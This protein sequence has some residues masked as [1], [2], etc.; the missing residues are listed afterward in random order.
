M[1]DPSPLPPRPHALQRIFGR[2]RV[3]IGM[4]HLRPLP[5]SPRFA[6][7]PV[8]EVV[9]HAVE[10]ALVYRDAG[11]DGLIVE[12]A[13]DVPFPKPGDH[14]PETAAAMAVVASAVRQHT[15]LPVGI[16]VLANGVIPSLAVA[17]AAGAGFVRANQWV[18]AY[19]ANEGIV[20]GP[21]PAATR[22]R[23]G[24]G[25]NE[26]AVFADVRVKHG[27]HAIVADRSLAE[28]ARDVQFFDADV[29]IATGQRTGDPTPAAEVEVLREATGQPV[30]IG[31]GMAADQADT[32][33]VADG[34]IVGSSLKEGGAWWQPLD[35]GRVEKM[36]AVAAEV[37]T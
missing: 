11:F 13:W 35:P 4:L 12:N 20:E 29:L 14:G 17:K 23:A 28:Q 15:A 22:Y 31:S 2:R 32:L 24:I 25:A 33:A 30:L 7:G 37:W 8:D 10:E 26:V 19:V 27:S 21:A 9:R 34:A 3:L 1:P 16:N 36:A 18:N 5:G 6:G